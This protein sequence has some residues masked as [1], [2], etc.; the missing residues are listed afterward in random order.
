MMS[1]AVIDMGV[2][3]AVL[4]IF[5]LHPS[6]RHSIDRQQLLRLSGLTCRDY[7]NRRTGEDAAGAAAARALRR[8]RH[9]GCR[10]GLLQRIN[11]G[12]VCNRR[13]SPPTGWARDRNRNFGGNRVVSITWCKSY[14]ISRQ[15]K[16]VQR[17]IFLLARRQ[18][19]AYLPFCAVQQSG[20]LRLPKQGAV[21]KAGRYP[22]TGER[23]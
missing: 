17:S 20:W 23:R 19:S 10:R 4:F 3:L 8:R 13:I 7:T 21:P 11:R 9:S 6:A 16:I 2:L 12:R 5:W 18:A 15:E 14:K 22:L 1:A